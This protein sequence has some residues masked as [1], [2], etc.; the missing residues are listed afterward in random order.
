ML[1]GSERD[2]YGDAMVG[3]DRWIR[4]ADLG[5]LMC[6]HCKNNIACP[7]TDASSTKAAQ[8]GA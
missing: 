6:E 8:N 1:S 2:F 3:S 5:V 7:S 4:E